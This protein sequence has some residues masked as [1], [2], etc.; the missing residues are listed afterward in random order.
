VWHNTRGMAYGKGGNGRNGRSNGA[1]RRSS[2]NGA[3]SEAWRDELRA[4]QKRAKSRSSRRE[5]QKPSGG[6]RAAVIA[7]TVLGL[8]LMSLVLLATLGT[9]HL[10][11]S[12]YAAIN[13]DLPSTTQ[14]AS[15]ETFKTAQLYDRKGRLLWEFFDPNS[16]RRTVVPLTEISQYLI[17]A[18]LAA[19]DANFYSNPGIEPRGIA[20]AVYQNLSEQEIVSG[21]STITQQL[22]K[23]VLIPEEER[24]QQTPSRKVREALLAYQITQKISKSQILALYMNEIFYGNQA[25]GVEAASQAYFGKRA[26]ELTLAEASML[27]GLPQSPALYNPLLNPVAAKAR[28]AYVLEQMVRHGFI[29]EA[30]A[31]DA[32]QAELR[33][34][35]QKQ[36]FLAPHWAIHIRSL[37]EEK[38]GTRVLYQS[39]MKIYTSLDYD[40]QV[41]MEEVARSNEQIL[42][43][44]DAENTSIV[45]MNPKTGEILAMVGSMDYWNTNIEGQVNVALSERQ[46]GS[47]IKP[48]VYLS[49]FSKGWVP[50]TTIM[51]EKISIKDELGRIWTPENYDKR[52][53]GNV[54]AR[55]ALGNSLNIPAVK[56]LQFTGI[57]SV[58][59]LSRKMGITTWTDNSRLGLAMALGGA[60]VRPVDLTSAYTVLANNG[61]RIPPVSITKII[62]AE[63]NTVEEYKVPQGEQVVD[64]RYAYMVTSVLSDNDARLITFGPNSVLK[65]PR[66]AA[67]KTGTTDSYRDTWT[68][69]YTP[70][71]T[72]GV[73]VG[74]TDNRPMKEVLSSMSA[75]KIWRESM[76]TAIDYLQL[77]AEEFPRPA[78]LVDAQVCTGTTCKADLFPSESVPNGAR[79]IP[80]G[81]QPAP[82]AVATRPPAAPAARPAAA[83]ARPATPAPEGAESEGPGAAPA[84]QPAQPALLPVAPIVAPPRTQGPPPQATPQP[85]GPQPAATQQPAQQLQPSDPAPAAKPQQPAAKPQQPAP[86]PQ[87]PAPKP[88]EPAAKP[89]QPAEKPQEPATKPQQ[90]APTPKRR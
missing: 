63:G 41:K 23:N 49:S 72:I 55:N 7:V 1:S 22:V 24:Y 50:A 38:Y 25:Y 65:L 28:Q 35:P 71:L 56:T 33:Y 64:P 88:Q 11:S 86:K 74:N 77:P 37:I 76:D 16:G 46:P 54:T 45:V 31:R 82:T 36:P 2:Q 83:P 80:P 27:A 4:L 85:S 15:R 6:V 19:E 42:A 61:L 18:T 59:E 13:R 66:Q 14:L 90:P 78:G 69:G 51:D 53:H 29:T 67:V 68:L 44:R 26:R 70:N 5:R 58:A 10:A 79:I 40:L 21:A 48:L 20:R 39:G 87:E 34:Q 57:E 89:Q 12:A 73:W 17:D 30:E 81:G 47:T 75:G 60:E 8:G 84:P 43:Q 62:D 3:R 52:F 9:M 32:E